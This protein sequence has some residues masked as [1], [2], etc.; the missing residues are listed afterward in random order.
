MSTIGRTSLAKVLFTTKNK[1]GWLRWFRQMSKQPLQQLV[2]GDNI[3]LLSAYF[4]A[5]NQSLKRCPH[6]FHG[7]WSGLISSD[8][9]SLRQLELSPN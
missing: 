1:C 7:Y 9:G 5:S 3:C 6:L 2:G 4:L 8:G